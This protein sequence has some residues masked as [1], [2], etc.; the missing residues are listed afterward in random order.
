MN[1]RIIDR[2]RGPEI[3][4]TRI[5]VYRI[6]DFVVNNCSV[7]QVSAELDLTEEQVQV[8]LNYIDTHRQS[9]MREYKNILQRVQQGN[10]VEVIAGKAKSV[11]ELKQRLCAQRVQNVIHADSG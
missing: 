6:M 11:D 7:E 10:P 2:G 3:E 8:A 1:A 9:V 4:G 5:T